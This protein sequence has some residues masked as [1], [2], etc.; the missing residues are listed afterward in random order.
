VRRS[1]RLVRV[2]GHGLSRAISSQQRTAEVM[3]VLGRY[4][5]LR[6]PVIP[7]L[8]AGRGSVIPR[9]PSLLVA[10]QRMGIIL[11][12]RRLEE[13]HTRAGGCARKNGSREA[14]SR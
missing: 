8:G 14:D 1:R 4:S 6:L 5:L 3:G 13:I 2:K 10:P 12:C 9:A 7:R 11:C